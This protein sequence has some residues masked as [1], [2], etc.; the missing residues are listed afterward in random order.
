MKHRQA[1]KENASA[2]AI[3]GLRV[4]PWIQGRGAPCFRHDGTVRGTRGRFILD[5][6]QCIPYAR[7]EQARGDH[8]QPADPRPEQPNAPAWTWNCGGHGRRFDGFQYGCRFCPRTGTRGACERAQYSLLWG[9]SMAGQR[10]SSTASRRVSKKRRLPRVTDAGGVVS[11]LG[12][13]SR[14]ARG[15]EIAVRQ[16]LAGEQHERSPERL[17]I[18]R[19]GGQDECEGPP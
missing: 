2:R 14:L 18:D 16:C 4:R 13:P 1:S 7:P 12:A 17:L 10:S 5:A 3:S 8:R 9:S 6:G 15:R 11:P 19:R